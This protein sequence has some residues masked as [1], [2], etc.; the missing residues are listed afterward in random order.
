MGNEHQLNNL[1]AE[2][3]MEWEF[4][5]DS[6][7]WITEFGNLLFIDGV[8]SE[9]NPSTDIQ[10]AWWVVEKFFRVEIETGNGAKEHLVTIRDESGWTIAYHYGKTVQE[11]ICYASLKA[12]G[13]QIETLKST[14]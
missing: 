2:K 7:S 10:D 4:D 1:V 12:C 6:E 14:S 8:D 5:V 9:W 3:V 11:A 13:V